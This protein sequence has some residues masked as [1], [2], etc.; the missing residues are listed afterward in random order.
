MELN[1]AL[2]TL[3]EADEETIE[4]LEGPGKELV[5]KIRSQAGA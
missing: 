5:H 2:K 1:K 3:V 4:N